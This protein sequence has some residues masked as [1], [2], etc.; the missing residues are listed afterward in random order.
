VLPK[1]STLIN[2][3]RS[4]ICIRILFVFLIVVKPRSAPVG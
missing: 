4:M 3:W 1:R 2:A